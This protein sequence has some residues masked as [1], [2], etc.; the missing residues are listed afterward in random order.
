MVKM[1]MKLV[2]NNNNQGSVSHLDFLTDLEKDVFKTA[3]E[4]NQKW[5]I[6]L[7]GDRTPYISQAQSVNL[8][9]QQMFIKKNYIEFILMWKKGLK[10]FTIADQNQFKEL[11]IS[12]M[13]NQLIL[14]QMYINLKINKQTKNQN[15]RS[16]YHVSSREDQSK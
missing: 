9:Y 11:K 1:M 2:Y 12:M 3:F 13:Q 15:T 16:V 5:I 4:L 14:Q 6:E 10:A 7:S 8:F